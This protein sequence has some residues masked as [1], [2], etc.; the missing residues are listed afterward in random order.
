MSDYDEG[1]NCPDCDCTMMNSVDICWVCGYG[2]WDE[3]ED[4]EVEVE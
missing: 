4:E 2:I 3:A 1:N